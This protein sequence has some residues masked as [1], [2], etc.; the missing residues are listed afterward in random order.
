M[1]SEERCDRCGKFTMIGI[2]NGSALLFA[3]QW[4]KCPDERENAVSSNA[5]DTQFQGF[6][7]L[8][9]EE[10]VSTE[11]LE[12]VQKIIARRAYDFACY[13]SGEFV[14]KCEDSVKG[15]VERIPDMTELPKES[16]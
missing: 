4:C 11:D 10:I 2:D 5:R 14:P 15:C 9:F 3:H 6:A 8:L 1:R 13:V 16:S 7:E 12:D